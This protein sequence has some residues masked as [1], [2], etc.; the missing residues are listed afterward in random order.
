M[1]RGRTCL[2]LR[3][4]NCFWSLR[5]WAVLKK[6]GIK[7]DAEWKT[8]PSEATKTI[9]PCRQSVFSLV[10]FELGRRWQLRATGQSGKSGFLELLE[11][12]FC[13]PEQDSLLRMWRGRSETIFHGSIIRKPV[14][15]LHLTRTTHIPVLP[16]TPCSLSTETLVQKLL[17]YIKHFLIR[18]EI[19]TFT[20]YKFD[21]DYR[22]LT[23]LLKDRGI[24]IVFLNGGDSCS[25][26]LLKERAQTCI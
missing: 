10:Y 21:G 8:S 24:N 19:D 1:P 26:F 7:V 9:R 2:R 16:A 25:L 15:I 4:Q 22:L 3:I 18:L 14:F 11:L 12:Y 6:E 23:I 20:F 5:N 13:T 17:V